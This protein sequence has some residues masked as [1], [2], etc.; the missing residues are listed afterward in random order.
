MAR[1]K[2][3]FSGGFSTRAEALREAS[4]RRRMKKY[5]DDKLTVPMKRMEGCY[6]IRYEYI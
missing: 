5:K 3:G 6:R 2:I 1:K 4:R